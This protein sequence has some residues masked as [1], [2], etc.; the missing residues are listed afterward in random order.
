MWHV[1]TSRTPALEANVGPRLAVPESHWMIVR[2]VI[3]AAVTAGC[4]AAV[5]TG[6]VSPVRVVLAVGFLLFCPGLALTEVLQIRDLAQRLAIAIGVS[7]ALAT[8]ISLLL[9]YARDFSILLTVS[10]LGAVTLTALSSGLVR[11]F[12]RPH[13]RELTRRRERPGPSS[14]ATCCRPRFHRLGVLRRCRAGVARMVDGRAR[15]A[16]R[17]SGRSRPSGRL[18]DVLGLAASHGR[19]DDC[20]ASRRCA[21]LTPLGAEIPAVTLR[22]TELATSALGIGCAGLYGEPTAAGRMRLLDAA[23][24]SGIRHFDTAPMYGLGLA[25]REIGRFAR[26]RRGEIVIAT[27]F[28]IAPTLAARGIAPLQAP[29]RRLFVRLPFAAE[30]RQSPGCRAGHWSSGLGLIP[31]NRV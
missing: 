28:G 30:G 4:I 23:H 14:H 6:W 16:A 26:G 2:A 25:E 29:V 27:K 22:G 3:I 13:Q 1:N 18:F 19:I 11:A 5:A 20:G 8:L 15:S 21:S 12:Y 24:G 31:S 9:V 10:I 17:R 7:I